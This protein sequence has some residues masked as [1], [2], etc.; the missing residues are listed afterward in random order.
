MPAGPSHPDVDAALLRLLEE[1]RT[2]GTGFDT[3]TSP[4]AGFLYRGLGTGA[5]LV[6]MR[7][8]SAGKG[9]RGALDVVLGG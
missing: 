3:V 5:R 7:L 6:T 9:L 8:E 4:L 2:Q 1:G